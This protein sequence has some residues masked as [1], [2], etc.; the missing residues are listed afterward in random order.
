M[1]IPPS[2][3]RFIHLSPLAATG[4]CEINCLRFIEALPDAAHDVL[5]FDTPG[6]MSS[7]W[8][9]AGARL[10]H[11]D[12]WTHGGVFF[13][14]ALEA[15]IGQQPQPTGVVYWSTSRLHRVLGALAVWRVPCVVHLGNPLSSHWQQR[16]RRKIEAMRSP[17]PDLVAGAACSEHVAQSHRLDPYFGRFPI[18]VIQNPVDARQTAKTEHRSLPPGARPVLGMVARLDAIKDHLTLIRMLAVLPTRWRDVTLEFAGDGHLKSRLTKAARR[19]GV[20]DRVRFLGFVDVA[21]AFDR[22]DL[23]LHSTTPTEGMGTALAEA[24][25]AGLPCVAS[26][27]PMMRE[28]GG[29][30]A[31]VY[32]PPGEASRW[33][34]AVEALLPDAPR[35]RELGRWARTR[36]G[37]KFAAATMVERYLR[38]LGREDRT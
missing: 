1:N 18:E 10:W 38:L 26:D 9:A 29:P 20:A 23:Y 13:A 27:L 7:R 32:A 5:V 21:T 36:A 30:Q 2:T 14:D 37:E 31:V 4:G 11:L 16:L 17:P 8:Q 35:R 25:M 15:W 33:A 22:W 19:L 3:G 12:A 24:M 28:V 6:P 34:H